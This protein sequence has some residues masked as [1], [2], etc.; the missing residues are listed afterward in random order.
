[1]IRT[2]QVRLWSRRERRLSLNW[3]VPDFVAA[4][5]RVGSAHSAAETHFTLG[6]AV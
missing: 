2:V 5:N 1:M 6:A 4:M 3:Q